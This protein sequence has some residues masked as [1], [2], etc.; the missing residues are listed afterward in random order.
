M[1]N[2][3]WLSRDKDKSP[4]KREN[5][6]FFGLLSSAG[7]SPPSFSAP[8]TPRIFLVFRCEAVLKEKKYSSGEAANRRKSDDF[9]GFVATHAGIFSFQNRFVLIATQ[10]CNLIILRP[11]C[12]F[13]IV[14]ENL[15]KWWYNRVIFK[16]GDRYANFH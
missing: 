14:L 15:L 11:S 13:N 5:P 16:E 3:L 10:P 8:K 4:D 6:V 2:G 7:A 12:F 1:R 9:Q